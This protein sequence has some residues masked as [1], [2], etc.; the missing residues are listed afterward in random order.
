ME[1]GVHLPFWTGRCAHMDGIAFVCWRC[2]W[3]CCTHSDIGG[4]WKCGH[5]GTF[6]AVP[7]EGDE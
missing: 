4:L 7:Q 6:N 1:S 5:C 3:L 2:E